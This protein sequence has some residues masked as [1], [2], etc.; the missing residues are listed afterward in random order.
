M[1]QRQYLVTTLVLEALSKILLK[2]RSTPGRQE[3]TQ[4]QIWH[5][6]AGFAGLTGLP[7]PPNYGR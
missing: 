7:S 4:M 3:K 1:G 6:Y 5:I 2:S